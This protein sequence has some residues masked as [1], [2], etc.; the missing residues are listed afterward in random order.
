MYFLLGKR[1][2]SQTKA[3]TD[4]TSTSTT[5]QTIVTTQP[6]WNSVNFDAPKASYDEVT[7]KDINVS[8]N[9][10]YTIYSLGENILFGTDQ[11]T[12][13]PN[14]EAKLKQISASLNKRFKGA[15]IGVY[16]NTDSTG[17][18]AANKQLGTQRAEAVKNWLVQNGGFTSDKVSIHS[19]GEQKPLASNGSEAGK[20]QNRSVVIVAFPD[21][22]AHK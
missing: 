20:Q 13:Q 14:A 12:V 17:T 7:E 5:T 1:D 15:T 2:G 18:A 16:G 19:F 4:S 11:S 9:D 21:S 6:D 10:K 22:S 8:G 3:A